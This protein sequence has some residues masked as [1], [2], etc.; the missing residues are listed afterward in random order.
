MYLSVVV[1]GCRIMCNDHES[2]VNYDMIVSLGKGLFQFDRYH[3][4]DIWN[5]CL[6]CG[7]SCRKHAWYQRDKV[8]VDVLYT[9]P[10]V[11]QGKQVKERNWARIT[12]VVIG[13]PNSKRMSVLHTGSLLNLDFV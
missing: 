12:L 6:T 5:M 1:D 3:Y 10:Q 2:T 13:N 11:Q 9:K 8:I 4:L 7:S